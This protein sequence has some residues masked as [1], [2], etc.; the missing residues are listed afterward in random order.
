ML[1]FSADEVELALSLSD[2]ADKLWQQH[3]Q[4]IE[5]LNRRTT[6]ELTVWPH[7]MPKNA[8]RTSTQ[9]KDK[10]YKQSIG[11]EI[12]AY[13]RLQLAM[14]YW[15]ALWFWPIEEA[16]NLPSR[17]D[18][19]MDMHQI[20]NSTA[21]F[22]MQGELDF[23][24]PMQRQVQGEL[25]FNEKPISSIIKESSRLTIVDRVRRQQH[26]FHWELSCAHIFHERAGFDLVVGNPPWI[27]L[28][29]EEADLFSEIEPKILVRS[30]EYSAD[31]VGKIMVEYI[32][33][34]HEWKPFYV[35]EA[36]IV[37]A[38][39]NIL[40]S[41]Q[42]YAYLQGLQ[43]NLF[44]CFVV[45]SWELC[46]TD[47]MIGFIHPDDFY[48]SPKAGLLKSEV[49]QRLRYH[50]QFQNELLLFTEIKDRK[51]YSINIYGSKRSVAFDHICNIF[52]PK[53][54]PE[55]YDGQHRTTPPEGIKNEKGQW[56]VKGHPERVLHITEHELKLFASLMDSDDTPYSE[57]SLARIHTRSQLNALPKIANY[58]SKIASLKEQVFST[59]FWDET[60]SRKDGTIK[61]KTGFSEHWIVSGPHFYVAAPYYKT[62]RSK[63]ITNSDYD[64][65]DLQFIPDEYT[66]RTNYAPACTVEEYNKRCPYLPWN[67]S[68]N[69]IDTYKV[70]FR[71]M[72]DSVQERTLIGALTCAGTAHVHAVRSLTTAHSVDMLA[73][74]GIIQSLIGDYYIKLSGASHIHYQWQQLPFLPTK[75]AMNLR[76]L[77]L[78][79]LTIHYDAFWR[80][81]WQDSY[82]LGRWYG[83]DARLPHDFWSKLTPHWQRDCAL[84]NDFVRRWALCELDVI[85]AREIGLTLV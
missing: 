70:A 2:A 51:I 17:I 61:R 5:D 7:E 73:I 22:Q 79:C 16:T 54:L 69:Y 24:E 55:C 28:Q 3:I 10:E 4:D 66:P 18:F 57:A 29:F 31:K 35:Q 62:P 19:L 84:R 44:L 33:R 45:H 30:K 65:I 81:I 46:N 12:S 76:V 47:A 38:T 32:D 83:D 13:Q 43:P 48:S 75:P 49:Y 37:D 25:G 50:F 42:T 23:G 74:A 56:S 15:C 71:A 26:F 77:T 82:R 8:H 58:P 53:A 68:Q 78:N 72:L 60:N 59:P 85:V 40:N 52:S 39:K 1:P 64:I 14:D 11:S 41:P 67:T 21:Q 27:K 6:D 36:A 20:L 34:H 9:E 80:E 63:C